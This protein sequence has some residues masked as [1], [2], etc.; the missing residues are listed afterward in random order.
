MAN[1]WGDDDNFGV[2][3]PATPIPQGVVAL[4]LLGIQP[5]QIIGGIASD[6]TLTDTAGNLYY[7]TIGGVLR[8]FVYRSG[9]VIIQ[10]TTHDQQESMKPNRWIVIAVP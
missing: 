1:W 4:T 10:S 2:L 7:A 9:I 6:A 5:R 8:D 3:L